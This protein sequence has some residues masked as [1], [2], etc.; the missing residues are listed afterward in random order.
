MATF[1]SVDIFRH[2]GQPVPAGNH[3]SSLVEIPTLQLVLALE[4]VAFSHT[5]G[6]HL[7]DVQVLPLELQSMP[8]AGN[9]E[10]DDGRL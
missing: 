1:F 3:Q 4:L 9:G 5:D 6:L 8:P 2:V 7:I 10:I